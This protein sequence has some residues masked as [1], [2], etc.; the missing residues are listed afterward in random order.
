MAE[1][2]FE[3]LTEEIPAWMH[4]AAQ[5]T[6]L[7]QLTK[8]TQDL[9]EPPD[10][11]NPVV[12]NS[13]PRRI[14]FFLSRIPLRE[15]DREEEVKGPPV[16]AA[17]DAEGKPTQAL[18]GFLKKNSATIDDVITGG[19]YI[20]VKR[21]IKG[22]S[23][24]EILQER[25]PPIIESLRWPKMMR[26]G[27]GEHSYIRPIHSVVSVL[28][29]EHLPI[30]IFD[31]PSGATTRGHR[32]LAPQPIEVL[33]YNDYVTKLELAR[34]VIDADRRRQVMAERARVLGQQAGGTPS[35]DPSIW[36][37]WQYL[38][39]YPGVVRAEFGREY[40]S[41]PDEVL[42]TVM[43]VHQKQLPIRTADGRLTSFFLAVLDNDA[44]PD[45]NAAY[46]NSFVTNARFADAKFFYETDRKRTLESRLDQLEHLQ[47]QEKLG[48]YRDKTRRIE[49]IAAAI[50]DDADTLAAA[51]LCKTD[52]PTEMVKEFTD[53]QGKIGGIYAREEGLPENTWQAIYDH[54]L[55]VNI[56]DALPRTLS[57][58]IVS[59]AD[60]IDTLAG[61]FRIGAKPTGSKD[62]FALRRAAQG[63]VQI[64]LNRDKRSLKIGIDKLID[65][66]LA[67][68]QQPSNPATQQPKDDLL[69]FFAERVRTILEASAYGFAYDEIAAAMEAGWASSLT[70]LVDRITALKAMRNEPNF[71]SILDSAKRIANITSGQESA[72]RVDPSKLESDT[73]R[74][75]AELVPLMSDQIDEMIGE[76]NYKLALETFAAMAPELETF[77]DEVMVMVEDE[78][79]RRNRMALLRTVGN[80]VMKIADVTRIVVNRRE[81]RA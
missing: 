9:G 29:G 37:Q 41:L 47:F 46:G 3:L 79:V 6:L 66:A 25:V 48:N 54:Y 68:H 22:R 18:N 64:L 74:R 51:R 30:T 1:Y 50:S 14:I 69:A 57:G 34:V 26:W 28:D 70:D 21:T 76:R 75:L 17:Y 49:E 60:K 15:S 78:G 10:D 59:L 52:L 77:F 12:V 58:T 31:I 36:S 81:Y 35:V 20:R 44:D 19:D 2:F 4:T 63:I 61:F 5:A 71:L 55:P 24:G 80:A 73:E 56:D 65:I 42:V 45:G 43:R 27:K 8:L 53:L 40:L 39:E 16:K 7:Q 67:A 32:T 13:T 11:R 72:A 62:P 23:A 38:T 33:S